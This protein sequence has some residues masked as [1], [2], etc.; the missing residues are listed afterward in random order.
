MLQLEAMNREKIVRYFSTAQFASVR[1]PRVRPTLQSRHG[2]DAVDFNLTY[3]PATF[4]VPHKEMFDTNYMKALYN[5]GF[6]A[7]KSNYQWQ[8]SPPGFDAPVKSRN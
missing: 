2:S 3:I 7:A 4:D 8:K 1:E 6:E 5:V